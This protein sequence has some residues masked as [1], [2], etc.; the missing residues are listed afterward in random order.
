MDRVRA[1]HGPR[2]TGSS[3]TSGHPAGR[4]RDRRHGLGRRDGARDGRLARRARRK[5]RRPRRSGSTGRS[6][7]KRFLAALPATVRAIA[8]LD[9]TKEPGRSGEPLYLDVLA[10][11]AT[12]EPRQRAVRRRSAAVTGSRR[13]NSRPPWSRPSSTSSARGRPKRSLHRRHHRRRDAHFAL[14]CDRDFDIEAGRRRRAPSSSGSAPTAPWAR[15]RTRSRSS[16]R[17]RTTT[18]RATSSTTRRS[19]A[20]MTVSHLRFGPRPIRSPYLIRAPNFVACHQ[21]GVSRALDVLALRRAGRGFPA[22]TP[23]TRPDEVWDALPREV[24][25]QI[26]R[27]EAHAS[28]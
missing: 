4:A 15:T 11:L 23:L 3:T 10:A 14:D 20:P 5:G 28:T 12:T 9:R 13:R 8:V 18:P 21:F 2:R 27:E 17:R 19:R 26:D 25:E 16:A 22:R 7:R 24:Q 6:R 1:A